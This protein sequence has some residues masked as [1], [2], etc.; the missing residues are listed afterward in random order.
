MEYLKFDY[1]LFISL[2]LTFMLM[3]VVGTLSHEFGHYTVSKCLGYEASINYQSSSH[4]D[5]TFNEYLKDTYTK[6]SHEIK[7]KLDFPGKEKY[8]TII[9][10]HQDD[11]FWIVLGG[12]F[13]TMLTGSIG[14][15]LLLLYSHKCISINR[16]NLKG[17]SLIFLSLFWLRQVANLF[18]A[19]MAY[20]LKGKPSLKG[21]EM[22]LANHLDINIWSIQ[23][24][25]G[26]AGAGV[27][28]FVLRVLPK[29][30]VLTFLFSGLVGGILGYYLWLIKFGQY[31]M[32]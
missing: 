27:L 18:M 19:L 6:Y 25:S 3:T 2:T 28:I 23:I 15:I 32:P 11:N 5:T 29:S 16:V 21:D 30:V 14:F 1:K 13:Q 4:W 26:I 17:W 10:K 7:N 12:P 31:I 8:Q 20:I 9:K 24:L 22:R